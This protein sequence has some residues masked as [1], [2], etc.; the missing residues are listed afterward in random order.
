MTTPEKIEIPTPDGVADAY[1]YRPEGKGPW[2]AILYLPDAF[3]VRPASHQMCERLASL[4]YFVLQPNVVYRAGDYAPFDV[5]T[6]FTDPSERARIMGMMQQIDSVRDTGI[7][8]DA[9]GRQPGALAGKVGAVG[10]CLGGRMAFIAAAY[11]PDRVAAVASIHGGH[12]VTDKDD[13]PHKRAGD[14]RARVYLAVADDDGSCTPEHQG[15]LASSLG[16]AHVAYQIELYPGAHHGFAVPDFA[17]YD[18][19]AAERHWARLAALFG[20]ALPRAAG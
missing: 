2:P 8:L 13:S 19:V 4:G 10:Y 14:L 5:K 11:H 3:A 7:Y 1:V 9:I 20:E 17:I 12:I 15:I 16:A 18:A 6:T